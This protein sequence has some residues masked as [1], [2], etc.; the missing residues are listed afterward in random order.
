MVWHPQ[1]EY[2]DIPTD[3]IATTSSAVSV[4]PVSGLPRLD[5]SGGATCCS[6][7]LEP[8]RTNA[9]LW[10]EQFDN[11]AWTKTA[12]TTITA[13]ANVSPSGY[14]D[15]DTYTTTA[16]G[17]GSQIYRVIPV[18]GT[19]QTLSIFVKYLSGSGTNLR[20]S[21]GSVES[22]GVNLTFSNSGATLNGVKGSSV[23]TLNIENYGNNW[24]RVSISVAYAS[25]FAEYNLFRYAGSGT[26]AYAIWGAQLEADS[27][28]ATSYI[29]TLSTAVTRVAESAS[30]TGISSLIGQ[31]EG[32]LFVDFTIN[33]LQDFGTPIS[34]NDGTTSNYI[35]FT[36]F[37]NGN[38][39]VE[40]NNGT[41]QS[42]ITYGGAVVGGRYK[43]AF[44]YKTN[45]FALYVN[46][47]QIGTDNSG[48]TFSGTTLSRVDTDIT[49]A[50][51]YSTAS[52]SINQALLF[53][54]RLT[55]A[56]LAELT[57]L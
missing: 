18:S 11:A 32:T 28:Y 55:N 21:I 50:A 33:G 8:Q 7:L 39:R 13:N 30:K 3:Y 57:T 43:M 41:V 37:S 2:G 20:L 34:V 40:L 51:T 49:D 9:A 48:T 1:G 35:W 44:G 27:S 14:Q 12:S 25:A 56:Q 38:L 53:T 26:D 4:G 36:I 23:S 17:S 42:A 46:G 52:E 6:L 29:P 22:L 16:I 31:T 19:T 47:A 24:F 45:D 54:T 15:A 10:S 5:Y